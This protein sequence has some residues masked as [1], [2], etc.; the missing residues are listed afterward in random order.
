M[1][2]PFGI[3]KMLNTMSGCN[4]PTG[5]N[6]SASTL[7]RSHLSSNKLRPEFESLVGERKTINSY[8]NYI[9]IILILYWKYII[10]KIILKNILKLYLI[11]LRLTW[12]G[13]SPSL[14]SR[15]PITR[16]SG[17]L[18]R[19]PQWTFW[20]FSIDNYSIIENE[21]IH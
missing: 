19:L 15:P 8:I 3:N 17:Q 20:G 12:Y 2:L 10:L 13:A 16:H 9:Y 6:Q 21:M 14:A 11:Y 7:M 1:R 5:W 4:N 18:P